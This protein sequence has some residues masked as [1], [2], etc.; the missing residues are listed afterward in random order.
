ML[1]NLPGTEHFQLLMKPFGENVL[2]VSRV[3]FN[4][5]GEITHL[6]TIAETPDGEEHLVAV[7]GLSGGV[8]I[9]PDTEDL[10]RFF[11]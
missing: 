1:L 11:R 7:H 2:W 10:E 4:R 3:L 5:A 9:L 8:E 6:L